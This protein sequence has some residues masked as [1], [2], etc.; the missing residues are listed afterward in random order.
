MI[1]TDNNSSNNNIQVS[2]VS[3]T[4]YNFNQGVNVKQIHLIKKTYQENR[5]LL[6]NYSLI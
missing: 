4:E 1:N 3:R 6:C 5:N 2:N